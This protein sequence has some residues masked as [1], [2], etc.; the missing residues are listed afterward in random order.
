MLGTLVQQHAV[1][2]DREAVLPPTPVPNLWDE[3]HPFTGQFQTLRIER[4]RHECAIV[5]EEQA[6]REPAQ[7][8]GICCGSI[9]A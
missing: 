9:G 8:W 4:L 1:V 2:G 6:W 5:D 3:N 7:N